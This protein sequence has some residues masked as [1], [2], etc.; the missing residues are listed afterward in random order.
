MLLPAL[1]ALAFLH[2]NHRVHGQL[3]PSNILAVDDQLKLASDSIRSAGHSANRIV[4]TSS[5]DAPELQHS[6]ISTAGDIWS[7]GMTL[8]EA[9]TQRPSW[10]ASVPAPFADTVRRCMS[11]TPA[12]RPTINELEAQYKPAPTSHSIS[13]PQPSTHNPREITPPRSLPKRQIWAVAAVALISLAAWAGLR[14]ADPSQASLQP[15]VVAAPT[16]AS[17]S[18]TANSAKSNPKLTTPI[19]RPPTQTS[20][21]PTTTSPSVVHEVRPDVPQAIREKIQGRIHVMVRVLVDPSGSVIAALMENPGRSKYFAR[22][23]DNAAREWQFAPADHRGARVWLLRFEFT[24]D[25][26]AVRASEQ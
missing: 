4:G 7:L 1:D 16:S 3:K 24:R 21:P 9:L 13:D 6:G 25:G 8:V 11:P 23:A 18:P 22:L 15:S 19:S 10:P 20:L 12:D 2:R 17:P 5:Y 14:L 26:V